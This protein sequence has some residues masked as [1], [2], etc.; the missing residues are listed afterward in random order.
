MAIRNSK[1]ITFLPTGLT[2]GSDQSE[3]F[4]GACLTIQNLVFNK[5]DIGSIVARPGVTVATS[6]PGF[7]TPTNIVCAMEIDGLVYGL[8]S[9]SRY[10]GKDEPF[11]YDAVNNVFIT[12]SNV[13][14]GNVPLTVATTGE[15][16]PPTMDVVGVYLLITHPGAS[17]SN[18]F[19]WIDL[20]NPAAPAWSAGN[21][22]TNSLPSA[23]TA[24]AQYN[25]RAYYVCGNLVYW[26]AVLSPLTITNAGD[27]LKVGDTSNITA[28]S[29]L[30]IHTSSQGILGGLIVF[31]DESLSQIT[32]DQATT[33]LSLNALSDAFGCSS[34][35]TICAVPEGVAFMATDGVRIVMSSDSSV[36]LYNTDLCMP[37]IRCTNLSRAVASFNNGIYRISLDT[38][39]SSGGTANSRADYWLDVLR[40]RWTGPHTFKYDQ[41]VSTGNSFLLSSNSIAGTF[42]KSDVLPSASTSYYDNSIGY[43]CVLL[44]ANMPPSEGGAMS[45]KCINESTV[46]LSVSAPNV[47]YQFNALSDRGVSIGTSSITPLTTSVTLWGASLWGSGLWS[48][49]VAPFDHTYSIEWDKPVIYNK[50]QLQ[51]TVAAVPGVGI[52]RMFF[53]EQQLGYTNIDVPL[54]GGGALILETGGYILL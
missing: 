51:I 54:T 8:V 33:N 18:K 41:V 37:F 24:V 29:G 45:T 7:T 12:I 14:T 11:C 46:D 43:D 48:A 4:P 35:L 27:A 52:E 34:P 44:S 31:K 1:P 19:F 15:W 32:G 53:R 42:L 49:G 47:N 23:P 40:R 20:T 25:N 6:F 26:S 21:T 13:L 2:D 39:D 22:S 3:T 5:T 28:L 10:S 16:V 50:L 30:P 9:T 38:M 36:V 17:G